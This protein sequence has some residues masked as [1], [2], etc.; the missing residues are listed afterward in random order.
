MLHGLEDH[1][2]STE[3]IAFLLTATNENKKNILKIENINVEQHSC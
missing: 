3:I 2:T 1:E